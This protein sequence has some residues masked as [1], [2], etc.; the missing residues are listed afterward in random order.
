MSNQKKSSHTKNSSL[1]SKINC[2][3]K[4]KNFKEIDVF[5]QICSEEFHTD[6]GSS[7]SEE[8]LKNGS[9]ILFDV[10]SD[11]H[12]LVDGNWLFRAISRRLTG[13]PWYYDT[14]RAAIV[15]HIEDNSN[16]YK[17]FIVRNIEDYLS[18]MRRNGV[19]DENCEVQEFNLFT[20]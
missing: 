12:E 9:S 18:K 4:I 16:K 13:G 17:N 3:L 14:L 8:S 11:I 1:K 20:M 2:S 15:Q 5:D 19:L 6:S 7:N 10:Y